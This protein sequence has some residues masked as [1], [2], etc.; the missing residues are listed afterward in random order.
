MKFVSFTLVATIAL[1]CVPA[2]YAQ[3]GCV[4]SPENPTALLA[5][6]G[7]AG[8]YLSARLKKNKNK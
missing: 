7:M 2:L 4:D 8:A 5:I 3:G 1:L 6:A